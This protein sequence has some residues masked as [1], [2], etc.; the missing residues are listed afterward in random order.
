[1]RK[2]ITLA[3]A[4]LLVS[5][6][7]QSAS[8]QVVYPLRFGVGNPLT[9][10]GEKAAVR[11]R[12][13]RSNGSPLGAVKTLVSRNM[14]ETTAAT[15]NGYSPTI[16][17]IVIY[18]NTWITS[19]LARGVYSFQGSS[20]GDNTIAAE[21]VDNDIFSAASGYGYNGTYSFMGNGDGSY[22]F[23]NYN[24]EDWTKTSS[25]EQ[26]SNTSIGLDLT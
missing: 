21:V 2:I 17:G 7:W 3:A 12:N 22:S 16:Y 8:A 19:T 15:G 20:T 24:V 23:F 6:F 5:V 18:D 4:A 26:W 11:V 10:K 1:M 9:A 13:V 14:P 25:V